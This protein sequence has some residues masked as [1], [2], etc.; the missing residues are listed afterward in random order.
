MPGQLCFVLIEEE[1]AEFLMMYQGRKRICVFEMLFWLTA[2]V[3]CSE[4]LNLSVRERM[5]RSGA[6]Y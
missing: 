3:R 2:F 5:Y 4:V 6:K 1:L